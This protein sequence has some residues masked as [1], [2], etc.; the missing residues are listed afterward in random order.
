M[1]IR[2]TNFQ[3]PHTPS[4][5]VISQLNSVYVFRYAKKWC[6]WRDPICFK[7]GTNL[8][9]QESCGEYPMLSGNLVNMGWQE[10][11]PKGK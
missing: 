2:K 1:I 7:N 11:P 5:S 9:Y 6:L 3:K 4:P 10:W 8:C